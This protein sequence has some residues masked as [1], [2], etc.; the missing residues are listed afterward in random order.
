MLSLFS[1]A[2]QGLKGGADI[3]YAIQYLAN[4]ID[5]LVQTVNGVVLLMTDTSHFVV[6][7]VDLHQ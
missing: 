3:A 5:T 7:N 6:Q 2:P 4:E 1:P